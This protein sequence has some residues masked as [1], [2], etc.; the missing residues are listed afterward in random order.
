MRPQGSLHVGPHRILVVISDDRAR[1]E[2]GWSL[3]AA[4]HEVLSCPGPHGADLTCVGIA[5][6]A[7]PLAEGADAVVLD[8]RLPG[9]DFLGGATGWQLG[10]LYRDLGL[11][12]V[13]LV[14]ASAAT[15]LLDVHGVQTLRHGSSTQAIREALARAAWEQDRPG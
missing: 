13:A 6:G 1:D 8:V 3:E 15:T 14:D 5:Q 7:C 12:V 4:G 11:P 10:L 9:D 2:I